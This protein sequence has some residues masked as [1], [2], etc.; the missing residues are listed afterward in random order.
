MRSFPPERSP[1]QVVAYILHEALKGF[2]ALHKEGKIH[3]CATRST[4][5]SVVVNR[6]VGT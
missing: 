3:R 4:F 2:A 1:M 6:A 5:W